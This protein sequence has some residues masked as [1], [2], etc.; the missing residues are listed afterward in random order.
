MH[1][2]IVCKIVKKYNTPYVNELKSFYTNDHGTVCNIIAI[3]HDLE[4]FTI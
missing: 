4:N 3:C 2:N 1:R